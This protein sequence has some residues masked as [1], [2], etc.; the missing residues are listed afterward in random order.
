ML[1]NRWVMLA[2]IFLVR[3]SM[4][5]MFQGVASVA[6]LLVGEFGLSY[7]QIGLLMGL[8]LL[9]GV[10]IAL[11]GGAL[12]QRFGSEPIAAAGLVLMVVGGLVT[13]TSAGFGVACVGRAVS[14][15]GGILLNLFLVKM[16]ADWFTGKEIS[17]ALG[18]MLTSWP[19]GIGL[20][21]AT[22]GRVAAV[23]SWRA[24]MLVTVAAAAAGLGLLLALYRRPPN[25]AA[26]ADGPARLVL[27]L[28]RRAWGL[29]LSAGVCWTV[30]NASVIVVASFGPTFLV[31]RGFSVARAGS[32][33]SFALWASLVSIPLGGVVAD[34]I[35]RPNLLITA[36]ALAAAACIAVAPLLP[37]PALWFALAGTVVGL[38]PGAIMALLPGV[39]APEHLATGLGALYTVFYL[40]VALAQPAAGLT[41]DFSGD[42]TMPILFAALLMAITVPALALFRWVEQPSR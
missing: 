6:P 26:S 21:L 15:A 24:S 4:G 8:F 1:Q 5:F 34:R 40:G 41:Q 20:A 38:A 28:P 22:L 37:F 12:G 2:V 17:T 7:G 16:V 32:L 31:A 42:P 35:R 30:L 3:T 25:R 27:D 33:V 9:P 36:G 19:V 39:L 18:V 14:G 13:A 23:W 10:I 11:P 29:A